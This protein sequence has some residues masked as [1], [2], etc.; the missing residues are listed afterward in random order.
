MDPLVQ[1]RPCHAHHLGDGLPWE[2]FPGIQHDDLAVLGSQPAHRGDDLLSARS[3]NHQQRRIGSDRHAQGSKSGI[4]TATPPPAPKA[5]KPPDVAYYSARKAIWT[6]GYWMWNGSGYV[7]IAGSWRIPEGVEMRW[8]APTWRP[9][10]RG[11][12]IYVPGGF[13][14]VG[15][16]R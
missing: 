13:V 11:T 9:T 1:G 7:W 3:L 14:R 8:V 2:V 5:E 6:P 10:R 16:R 15:P 4:E 12:L